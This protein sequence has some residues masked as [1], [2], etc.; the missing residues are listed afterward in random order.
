MS[1]LGDFMANLRNIR[2][3]EEQCE[4][5]GFRDEDVEGELDDQPRRIESAW[6]QDSHRVSVGNPRCPHPAC[7]EA[8]TFTQNAAGRQVACCGSHGVVNPI[9]EK[10]RPHD[11]KHWGDGYFMA[12][13]E[14]QTWWEPTRRRAPAMNTTYALRVVR[15]Q[16]QS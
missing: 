8:I 11:G 9:R 15:A 10:V 6:N 14:S 4:P 2:R 7:R 1:K 5:T 12:G 13:P 16:S 3:E